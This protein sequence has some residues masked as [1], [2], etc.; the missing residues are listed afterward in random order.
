[1]YF[2]L[3]LNFFKLDN[4]FLYFLFFYSKFDILFLLLNKFIFL[5][6]KIVKS[7]NLIFKRYDL[8]EFLINKIF[9]FYQKKIYLLKKNKLIKTKNYKSVLFQIS[10]YFF[11]FNNCFEIDI[12][13][14][15]LIILKNSFYFYNFFFYKFILW[16]KNLNWKYVN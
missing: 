16:I 10:K 3:N 15:S 8:I 13:S 11:N 14:Y 7:L 2:I 6:K 1:M 4:F 5:N 12:F 9:F